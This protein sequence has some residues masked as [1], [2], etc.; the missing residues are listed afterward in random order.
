MGNHLDLEHLNDFGGYAVQQILARMDAI[1][2]DPQ[3]L[4]DASR[5]NALLQRRQDHFV[6]LNRG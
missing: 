1:Y 6:F 4:G 3:Y 2:I 5:L